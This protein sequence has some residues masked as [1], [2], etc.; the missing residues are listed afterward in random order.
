MAT[1]IK[2]PRSPLHDYVMMTDYRTAY[3]V[4]EE[5]VRITD[6]GIV[7]SA[8]QSMGYNIPTTDVP[9]DAELAQPQQLGL[10]ER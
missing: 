1:V 9:A 10:E 5:L 6:I 4:L 8:L 7:L 3:E 2:A